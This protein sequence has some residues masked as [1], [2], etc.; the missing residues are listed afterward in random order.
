VPPPTTTTTTTVPATTTTTTPPPASITLTAVARSTG[1]KRTV[2]LRWSGANGRKVEIRRND[3]VLTTT[4]NDGL[5]SDNPGGSGTFRYRVAE[6]G[7]GRLSNEVAV[8]L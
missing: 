1:K 8:T 4:A 2:E 6:T 7:G 3:A 5:H